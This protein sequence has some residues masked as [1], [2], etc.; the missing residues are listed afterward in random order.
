MKKKERL[1]KECLPF[2]SGQ[3][4]LKNIT[5]SDTS[6][7]KNRELA[8][9]WCIRLYGLLS[10]TLHSISSISL[11]CVV[12]VP[13]VIQGLYE[14][15]W[16]V[17]HVR[18]ISL[19]LL[20]YLKYNK[21]NTPERTVDLDVLH[22]CFTKAAISAFWQW[23]KRVILAVW[24]FKVISWVKNIYKN[25]SIWQRR[26]EQPGGEQLLHVY[27]GPFSYSRGLGKQIL[28]N[29]LCPTSFPLSQDRN[30]MRAC[31]CLG[32]LVSLIWNLEQ[33]TLC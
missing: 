29:I 5:N 19:Q 26:G 28:C 1:D 3:P 15:S 20:S 27:N 11:G 14:S 7:N 18:T 6:Q 10:D 4:V 30:S 9:Q 12:K 23:L 8:E 33:Q 21:I 32:C 13:E 25:I 22:G 31:S 2:C 24:S 17:E 16:G